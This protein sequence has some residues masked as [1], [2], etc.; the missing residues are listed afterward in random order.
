MPATG[1]DCFCSIA[2][3]LA[4]LQKLGN[5]WMGLEPLKL[6]VRIDQR[7]AIIES[8]HITKIHHA[9]L[10]SVNPAAAVRPLIGR[11]A[12][13]MRDA[14]R[15]ITIGGQFPKFFYA[16]AVHLRLAAFVKPESLDQFFR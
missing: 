15:G 16:E 12:K 7:I 9:I 13:R 6:S 3:H 11:K 10:H 5:E 2:D 1:S 14:T 8:R 4:A